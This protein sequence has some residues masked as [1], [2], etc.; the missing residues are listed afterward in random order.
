MVPISAE[1]NI[2][3]KRIVP[4][5]GGKKEFMTGGITRVVLESR[6]VG[7]TIKVE[8]LIDPVTLKFPGG[9]DM[10]LAKHATADIELKEPTQLEIDGWKITSS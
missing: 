5:I 2:T 4:E 6:E 1:N 3:K 10:N 7:G 9:I 8:A